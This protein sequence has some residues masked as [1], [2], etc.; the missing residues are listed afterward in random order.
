M[1]ITKQALV[2]AGATLRRLS[3][4]EGFE[5]AVHLLREDYRN[6]IMTTKPEE[7]EL[8]EMYYQQAQSFEDLLGVIQT[9]IQGTETEFLNP[10][11]T[12]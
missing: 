5:V 11:E 6:R 9:L 2:N 10:E 1:E 3:N 12:E 8:R 7:R 4:S